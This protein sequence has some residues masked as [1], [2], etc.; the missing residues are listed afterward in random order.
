M[1]ETCQRPSL[2]DSILMWAVRLDLPKTIKAIVEEGANPNFKRLDDGYTP[3]LFAS[4]N[5]LLNNVKI[6]VEVGA[7]VNAT[8]SRDNGAASALSLAAQNGHKEIVEYLLDHGADKTL[9]DADGDT[10]LTVAQKMGH[11]EIIKLL[12]R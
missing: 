9:T 12:S 4:R 11:T 10:A 6:L 2:Q 3:L 5:G 1:R 8:T 7:D